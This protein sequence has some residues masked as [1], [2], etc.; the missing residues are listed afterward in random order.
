MG[1]KSII[2]RRQ[3]LEKS[4]SGHNLTYSVTKIIPPGEQG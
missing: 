1:K 4:A 2:R 3:L